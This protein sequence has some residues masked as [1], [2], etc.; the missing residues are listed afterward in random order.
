[1]NVF[2]NKILREYICRNIYAE[3]LVF[4]IYKKFISTQ[5]TEHKQPNKILPT[6]LNRYFI[7][8]KKK[9]G[10]QVHEKIPQTINN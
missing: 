5:Q 6:D 2:A 10:K 1:M 9:D 3:R 8:K 4:R 7:K